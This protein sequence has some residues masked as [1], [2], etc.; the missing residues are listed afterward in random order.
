MAFDITKA[1]GNIAKP[2]QPEAVRQLQYIPLDLIDRNPKNGYSIDGIDGLAAN[3]QMFGLMEPLLVKPQPN[4]RYML[5]SGHRRR[6]AL[7]RLASEKESFP[8]SMQEP[9]PCFVEP[10]NPLPGIAEGSEAKAREMAEELKLIFANSDTRVLNSADTAQQVRRIRELL[11]GL[12]ELGYEFPG[13]MRDH[14]A[15]AAKVSSS[16]IARLDVIDKGLQDATL[17]QAWEEGRLSETSAYE[18][19]KRPPEVQQRALDRVGDHILSSMKSE[20]VANFMQ[21]LEAEPGAQAAP[22]ASAAKEAPGSA[23]DYLERRHREDAEYRKLAEAVADNV[24]FRLSRAPKMTGVRPDDILEVKT[25]LKSSGH[26]GD[27]GH[28]DGSASGMTLSTGFNATDFRGQRS[29][30][31]FYDVIAA[32]AINRCVQQAIEQNEKPLGQNVSR[33]DTN[34]T[35]PKWSTG[36]PTEPGMY[37]ARIGVGTEEAPKTAV[38]QRLEWTGGGWIFPGTRKP[39]DQEMKVYRWVRLPE[40]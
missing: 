2:Q 3:I 32:I 21:S 33:V 18:I 13:R 15:A 25:E 4:G 34:P 35:A 5:I 24:F 27:D 9:V 23:D 37:E 39:L 36:D 31:E 28:W 7:R 11:L 22:E 14:V 6:A 1:L 16:R 19:A 17:R 38:W 26:T 40:V 12:K 29:W 8:E 30:T 20:Q 10:D